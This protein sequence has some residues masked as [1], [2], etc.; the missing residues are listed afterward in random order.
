ML[1]LVVVHVIS[2]RLP[3]K[4]PLLLRVCFC[5]VPLE[6]LGRAQSFCFLFLASLHLVGLS[7]S[8]VLEHPLCIP[9][10]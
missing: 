2:T 7:N 5:G 4:P 8:C 3:R 10:G 6:F 9:Q 1:R